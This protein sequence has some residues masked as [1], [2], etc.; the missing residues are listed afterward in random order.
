MK[1]ILA[2]F[3]FFTF[4]FLT[5]NKTKLLCQRWRQIGIKSF[6]KDFKLVDKSLAETIIFKSDGTFEKELYGS[7]HFNGLWLFNN[8]ST[9]LAM[10]LTDM[11]GT[12]MP[13]TEPFTNKYANDSIIKLTQ[14][15]LI[16]G[17]L[18][19]FGANKIY[20]HDDIYY[21]REK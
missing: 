6:N 9:K 16:D 4:C 20:G 12:K 1:I 21:V 8:D 19:Y 2:I 7:L 10:T 13:S 14:D 18:Q 3:L 15:T 5:D 11:N 17:Q